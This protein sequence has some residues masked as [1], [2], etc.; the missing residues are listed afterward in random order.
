MIIA[1]YSNI[2]SIES[3]F[4]RLYEGEVVTAMYLNGTKCK[5]K[6]INGKPYKV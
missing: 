4:I 1:Y 5:V 6:I 3:K 2:G